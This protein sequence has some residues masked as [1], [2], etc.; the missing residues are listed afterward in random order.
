MQTLEQWMTRDPEV[1]GPDDSA[2]EALERMTDGGFRHLPVVN[3]RS[4]VIGIVSIDDL[5]AALPFDVAL[6]TALS[7]R[8]RATAR[9]YRIA[10]V[11]TYLPCTAQRDTSLEQAVRELVG[12]RIG[13][14]PVLDA[15]GA[16]VGIFTE[17]DALRAL[18]EL[19]SGDRGG[20]AALP[21]LRGERAGELER[22]AADL[23]AEQQRI[24]TELRRCESEERM[25]A[26]AQHG[27]PLDAADRG[28]LADAGVLAGALAK[29]AAQRLAEI[30]C[31]LG[32]H[33]Q[34]TFG[35]CS[36][37]GREI[38]LARLRALP[39]SDRCVRCARGGEL[40]AAA[41]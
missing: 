9:H 30:D 7:A 6:G 40:H 28:S 5:R 21:D 38:P 13:C 41:G 15:H 32:R 20:R 1:L 31:A 37:C 35:S 36:A 3:E 25:L 18:L 17:S 33:A 27:E 2:L 11:M 39:S 29:F 19:V 4:G 8:G 12:R 24:A 26:A 23:R 22:L 34:H 16:L 14:L 10:E